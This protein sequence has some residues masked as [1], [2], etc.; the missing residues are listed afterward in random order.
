MS[1]TL[2]EEDHQMPKPLDTM[3][4][5]TQK[6]STLLLVHYYTFD[7]MYSYSYMNTELALHLSGQR[8]ITDAP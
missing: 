7:K 5:K 4:Q 3:T 2:S 1:P 6:G 8:K